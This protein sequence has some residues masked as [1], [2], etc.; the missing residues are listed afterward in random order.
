VD[1]SAAPADTR[2]LVELL[3]ALAEQSL[4]VSDDDQ[5]LSVVKK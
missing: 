5:P 2:P 3:V 1:C 4:Q